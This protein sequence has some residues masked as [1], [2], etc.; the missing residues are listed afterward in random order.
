MLRVLLG[1]I[2][3]LTISATAK[4]E[5]FTIGYLQLKKDARYAKTRT[6][7]QF[8][9]E[10]LGRPYSGAKVAMDEITFHG[11]GAGVTFKLDRE[12]GRRISINFGLDRPGDA[13]CKGIDFFVTDLPGDVLAELAKDHGRDGHYPVE[14]DST[15]RLPACRGLPAASCCI[16]S[17]ATGC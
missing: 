2:L 15:G 11:A 3:C 16:S 1:A 17:R 4:A 13:R 14:R 8:L 9:L 12:R 7:A 5:E 10:P 6:Y